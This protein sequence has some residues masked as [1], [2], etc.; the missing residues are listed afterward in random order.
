MKPKVIKIGQEARDALVKGASVVA[1]VV[2]CTLGPSGRN[3]ILGC[4]NDRPVITNDGVSIANDIYLEDEIENL[5]AQVMKDVA[6]RANDLAGDGTTTATVTSYALLKEALNR[7]NPKDGIVEMENGMDLKK[8]I[9]KYEGVVVEKLKA[10]AK[11]IKTLEEA[12]NVAAVSTES[13]EIGRIVAEAVFA[14][15]KDGIVTTEDNTDY[16]IEH[17]IINGV[18]IQSGYAHYRFINTEKGEATMLK[19]AVLVTDHA[20]EQIEQ[21][22]PIISKLNAEGKRH[23]VIIAE[24][25]SNDVLA[26]LIVSNIN[27]TFNVLPIKAPYI[28]QKEILND[29]AIA[30]NGNMIDK[31]TKKLEEAELSDIGECDKAISRQMESFIVGGKTDK[32]RL[33]EYANQFDNISKQEKKE[34]DKKKAKERIARIHGKCAVIKIGA[35]SETEIK[36]LKDKIDDAINATRAALEEGVVQG[37]GM[38]LKAIAESMEENILTE[39]LLT[40]YRQICENAGNKKL[41]VGKHI[42]DP[43]KVTRIAFESACSVVKLFITAG[44]AIDFKRE[45]PK[46]HTND[47]NA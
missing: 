37:G 34:W 24:R 19:P 8:E 43:V 2:G 21:V 42:V 41:K 40:P 23:L 13:Q 5:G 11:P 14:V 17:E 27:Q 15:G 45:E 30:V 22:K 20:I 32:K 1:E 39:A 36:Y 46:N 7:I 26:R 33:A 4:Q 28:R 9:E 31:E 10:M 25:F 35:K 29:I 12:I 38:A 47:K 16:K 44:A 6:K 3:V 18:K